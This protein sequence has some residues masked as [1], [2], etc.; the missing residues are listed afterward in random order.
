MSMDI[1]VDGNPKP[2]SGKSLLDETTKLDYHAEG[3]LRGYW[4]SGGG[5]VIFKFIAAKPQSSRL[6]AVTMVT[7]WW[8][9]CEGFVP[10]SMVAKWSR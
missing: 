3:V 4:I 10:E 5:Q 9:A 1:R 2:V 8:P 7:N 6:A